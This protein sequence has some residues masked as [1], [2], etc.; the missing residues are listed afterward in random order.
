MKDP[1]SSPQPASGLERRSFLK[2]AGTLALLVTGCRPSPE[3]QTRGLPGRIG[4]ENPNAQLPARDTPTPFP[5]AEAPDTFTVLTPH[6]AATVE[7]ATARILPGD[8]QD[9]G[10]R[11]AGV[12]YYIDHMLSYQEGFNEPTYRQAPYAQ[13]YTGAKPAD[14]KDVVWVPAEDIYRYGYQNIL[15][16]REVYRIGVAGLD[17]LAE[18]HFGKDFVDLTEDQQDTLI[19]LM[20]D[21]RAGR[22]DRNLSAESFFHNLR[23]HTAEGMFSDPIYGGNRDMVGWKLVGHPGAQ[24]AYTPAQYRTEG[25]GLRRPPQTF[26]MLHAFNPG[27]AVNPDATLP[28]SGEQMQH[29]P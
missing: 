8:A 13:T 10:A 12:V 21:G 5:P 6:E 20:A 1:T 3:R 9:P 16:P 7:A 22:F 27:Q 25:E 15:T 26:E 29:K 19:G 14:R 2:V 11:E 18:S 24:R 23:R 4:P 17:R 28:V